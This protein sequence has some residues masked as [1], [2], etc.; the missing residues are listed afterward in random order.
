MGDELFHLFSETNPDSVLLRWLRARKWEV[1]PAVQFMMD[2]LRWRH[3][4]GVRKLM[5]KGESELIFDECA[6]RK[7]YFM[8]KDKA[9]RPITYVHANEHIKGQFPLE[10]TGK[11]IILLM[12]IAKYLVEPPVEEGTVVLDMGNVGFKNLDYPYIKFMIDTMQNYYPECLGLALIVNAPWGFNTVWSVIRPWL[13]PVVES[14]IHFVKTS[15]GLAEYIDP[16]VLPRRLE[17]SQIDFEFTSPT[18]ED[19]TRLAVIRNDQEGMNK[20]QLEHREAAQHYLDVT[21]KWATTQTRNADDETLRSKAAKRLSDAYKPF[22]P[23]VSTRTHYHRIG[24]IQEPM[25][26]VVYDKI[27]AE[28]SEKVHL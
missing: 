19:E 2:T 10:S 27:C 28:S 17:G 16:A 25:F 3:E 20:A 14:K 5:T 15:K 24:T 11:L 6:S 8:G 18:K 1:S 23:Y 21:L 4:W 26:D 22:V 12:E 9:G 13:D 7:I